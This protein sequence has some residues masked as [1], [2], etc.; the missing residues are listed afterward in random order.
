MIPGSPQT[1]LVIDDDPGILANL[2][3]GLRLEGYRVLT[4]SN[5]EDG[6]VQAFEQQPDCIVLDVKMGSFS[7]HHVARA[8]RGDPKTQAIPLVMLS[9]LKQ[10]KE[11]F[12]G[13]A[14]GADYY[15]VKPVSIAELI[16][17]IKRAIAT[18]QAERGERLANLAGQSGPFLDQGGWP[19]DE[20]SEYDQG[21]LPGGQGWPPRRDGPRFPW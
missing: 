21:D 9:A 18:S 6:L 16:H 14:S 19:W 20:R 1:L 8:I 5:G 11:V 7:G 13:Q 2:A 12:A 15:L 17:T 10:A 3:F 4:A